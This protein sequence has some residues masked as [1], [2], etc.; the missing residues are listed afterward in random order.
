M[1][2]WWLLTTKSCAHSKDME[3]SVSMHHQETAAPRTCLTC[4]QSTETLWW[5]VAHR[6]TVPAN[7]KGDLWLLCFWKS[8]NPVVLSH[9]TIAGVSYS[10]AL[11]I[12]LKKSLTLNIMSHI[13]LQTRRKIRDRRKRLTPNMIKRWENW[14]KICRTRPGVVCKTE[15]HKSEV[16]TAHQF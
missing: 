16:P 10:W 4:S 15:Q 6:A 12:T 3:E 8:A 1:N 14:R 13:A 2:W 9:L 7:M 5:G 11:P